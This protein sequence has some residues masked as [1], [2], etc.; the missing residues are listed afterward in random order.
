ML[1]RGKAWDN[2]RRQDST[3][4]VRECWVGSLLASRFFLI[5]CIF[6]TSLD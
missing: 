5:D 3:T 2:W 4:M 1:R 6:V